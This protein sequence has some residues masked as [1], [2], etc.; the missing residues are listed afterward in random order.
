MFYVGDI[1]RVV[2]KTKDSS[3]LSWNLSMSNTI[4]HT[5]RIIS[6]NY[7]NTTSNGYGCPMIDFNDSRLNTSNVYHIDSLE[8]ETDPE[9]LK[10][11]VGR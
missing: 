8:L 10:L 9:R 1:V 2:R 4:G 7:T 6:V 11:W 3:K 5:G